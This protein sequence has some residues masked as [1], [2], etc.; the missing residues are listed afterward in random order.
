MPM[1]PALALD[2]RWSMEFV[3]DALSSGQRFPVLNIV[4]DYSRLS[5]A[6]EA[7]TS[8]PGVRVL[9]TLESAIDLHGSRSCS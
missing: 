2:E 9:R 4:D 5:P 3:S 7:D 8:V 6:I 1:W